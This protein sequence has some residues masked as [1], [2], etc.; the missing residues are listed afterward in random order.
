MTAKCAGLFQNNPSP[1]TIQTT[2]KSAGLFQL[3]H[4][5]S[6]FRR[7]QKVRASSS[8]TP[9]LSQLRR[10]QKVQASSSITPL[11]S[12]FRRQQK[13]GTLPV[14][15]SPEASFFCAAKRERGTE[16]NKKIKI[17]NF[18]INYFLLYT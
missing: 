8:I 11:L 18:K 9:L 6:Q 10:Q 1:E 7:Q 12:Q 2:A 17:L 5:L 3:T 14:N 4:L 16:K 15:P 13:C